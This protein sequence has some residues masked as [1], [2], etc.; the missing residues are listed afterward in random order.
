MKVNQRLEKQVAL[1][2]GQ[3]NE[4]QRE[5]YNQERARLNAL[6]L[7]KVEHLIKQRSALIK[8]QSELGRACA[9]LDNKLKALGYAFEGYS[10][11]EKVVP[12]DLEKIGFKLP[13]LM[14]RSEAEIVA[15]LLAATEAEG[16]ALLAKI[17]IMI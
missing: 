8:K 16:M 10:N 13:K 15:Q 1:A 4:Q 9:T 5:I 2:I 14:L 11:K 6:A 3:H 17:G 7:K 12:Q